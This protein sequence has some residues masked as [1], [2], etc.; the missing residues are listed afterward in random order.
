MGMSLSKLWETVKDKEA[1]CAA[2]HGVTKSQTGVSNWTTAVGTREG[3]SPGWRSPVLTLGHAVGPVLFTGPHGPQIMSLLSPVL[4]NT[5]ASMCSPGTV[6]GLGEV[7]CW[8][9]WFC[10]SM[11]HPRLASCLA[12]DRPLIKVGRKEE[13]RRECWKRVPSLPRNSGSGVF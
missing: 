8:W 5:S 4:W 10:P 1:W 2:V 12:C 7:I 9:H 3:T 11:C 13:S 6:P